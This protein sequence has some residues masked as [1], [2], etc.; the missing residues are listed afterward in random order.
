MRHRIYQVDAFTDRPFAGNPA[1]VMP[2]EAWLPDSVLQQIAAEMNLAETAFFVPQPESG[3]GAFH[4]RWF[5]PTV[6]I[7]LCGHATLA[8]AFVLN[9]FIDSSLTRMQF[10]SLSGP[11]F[12]AVE[13]DRLELDFPLLPY[14]AAVAADMPGRIAGAIGA[15]PVEVAVSEAYDAYIARLADAAAVRAVP[16]NYAAIEALGRDLI[17]TAPGE[18]EADFVSRFFAPLHGIPEDPVTGSSH[19]V[20]ANFWKDRLGKTS[21]HARQVSRR[22]GDLWLT[23]AGDR[24]K[25]AGHAV[26]VLTGEIEVS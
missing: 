12:V 13:G 22:G 16:A 11:L 2:L 6:E 25:I 21:F 9:R 20:L 26:C 19:C 3:A 5:T 4:L 15:V 18:G 17:V 24:L 7:K 10:E 23:M 14:E 1:G 8:S